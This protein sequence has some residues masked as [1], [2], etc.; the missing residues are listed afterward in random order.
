MQLLKESISP[1]SIFYVT[2]NSYDNAVKL[3]QL[4]VEKKLIACANIVGSAQQG[5]TSVYFW[6]NKIENDQEILMI[7]KSRTDLLREIVDEVKKNHPYKVPEIIATPIIGGNPDYIQW[8]I[9]ATK[10]PDGSST[11]SKQTE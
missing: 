1:L 11:E 5:I 3:S 2:I 10:T 6:E 9:G 8:V 4:L 7:M